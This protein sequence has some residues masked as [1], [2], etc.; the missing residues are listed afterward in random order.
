MGGGLVA[1]LDLNVKDQAQVGDEIGRVGVRGPA[2]FV[3][4][5]AL[6]RPFL[7]TLQRFDR[8][9]AVKH[10]GGAQA[11]CDGPIQVILELFHARR[12]VYPPQMAAYQIFTD[13]LGHPQ[14]RGIEGVTAQGADGRREW[15]TRRCPGD[16]GCSGQ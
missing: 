8:D 7:V 5:V 14:Q 4:V 13:H 16:R 3:G 12:F 2:G 15:P 10:P 1:G 11:R 9:I 6:L